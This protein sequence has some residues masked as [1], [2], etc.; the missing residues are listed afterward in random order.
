VS[1]RRL[2]ADEEARLNLLTAAIENA[3]DLADHALACPAT[4]QVARLL[5]KVGQVEIQAAELRKLMA[6]R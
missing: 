3:A 1:F 2:E 6:G 5:Q 4:P